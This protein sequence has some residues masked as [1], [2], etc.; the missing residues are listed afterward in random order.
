MIEQITGS[1][2]HDCDSTYYQERLKEL[3]DEYSVSGLDWQ[4]AKRQELLRDIQ[5]HEQEDVKEIERVE[6][7]NRW[8]SQL[9]NSLK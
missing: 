1:I 5:Y 6:G 2:E 8:I 9:R 4:K 3:G 7:R